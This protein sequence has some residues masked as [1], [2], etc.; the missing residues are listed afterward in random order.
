[1]KPLLETQK[2]VFFCVRSSTLK[3]RLKYFINAHKGKGKGCLVEFT[4]FTSP[5][6]QQHLLPPSF[7]PFY[8]S[9]SL[10]LWFFQC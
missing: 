1:M 10:L 7:I 5:F 4:G 6:M 9:V 3:L 2:S 8:T